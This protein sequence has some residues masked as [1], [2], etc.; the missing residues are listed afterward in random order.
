MRELTDQER[1][2]LE[3]L[4]LETVREQLRQ[5]LREQKER[6]D[7]G[8]RWIG[9][10]GTSPFGRGGQH[11]SGIAIGGS[12]GKGRGG[13]IQI[14]D[15]RRYKPYR[16]DA[17][18]DVRQIEVALRKLRLFA[19]EGGARELDL[20]RTIDQTARNA[21]ELE[22]VLRPPRTNNTR[23]I[24][25]MD[26]G[27]SM[28]PHRAY[29]S[30]LFTAAKRATHWKEL[31]TYYFHNCV[32]GRVWK[33]DGFQESVSVRELIHECGKRS[34]RQY[35]LVMLG[36]ALMAPYELMG[37][38]GIAE[39]DRI[40]GLEWLMMLREQFDRS[41]WLNPEHPSGWKGNTIEVIAKVFPMYPLTV[42][43]LGMAVD[44]LIK[45]RSR[46]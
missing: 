3:A 30:Q 41:V 33:T 29:V 4:D 5:R 15:A 45:G 38:A 36:D 25:M 12:S 13:A 11:P 27:G 14:A 23:V 44:E 7:G 31:R 46:R 39:D 18:L 37:F 22:V 34:G 1:A 28:E 40:T 20:D 17:T 26:V 9:T 32:Y 35:K 21:G 43:G 6:H 42:E 8:N 24:L 19:R 16:S 10:G 2:M